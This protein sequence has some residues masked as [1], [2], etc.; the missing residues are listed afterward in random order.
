MFHYNMISGPTHHTVSE[1]MHDNT[2]DPSQPVNV[3]ENRFPWGKDIKVGQS[4]PEFNEVGRKT[5]TASREH[6]R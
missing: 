4:D 2:F 5:T 3:N 6:R 1:E